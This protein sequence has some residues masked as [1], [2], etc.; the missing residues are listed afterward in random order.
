MKH[1]TGKPTKAEQARFDIMLE[2]GCVPCTLMGVT[3]N[4]AQIHHIV[5]GKKRLGHLFTIC[6]CPWHHTGHVPPTATKEE[7]ERLVGPS[8][9]TS[10]RAFKG[11]FGT[12]RELLETQNKMIEHYRKREY[13]DE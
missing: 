13:D 12:Q 3:C 8:Y 10:P 11:K 7:I 5:E 2:I 4:P 1:S 9:A 6:L